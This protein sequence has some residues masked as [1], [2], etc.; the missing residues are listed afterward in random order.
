MQKDTGSGKHIESESVRLAG[1]YLAGER[2]A[3]DELIRLHQK[4]VFNLCFRILGD[5]DEADDCAQEV[6]IKVSRSL[7]GFRLEA[8]FSTWLHRITVNTC[9]NRLNSLDYRLKSRKIR[10]DMER[11]M[12]QKSQ[13]IEIEDKSQSPAREVIR[14]ELD[15]L[16]QRAINSLPARQKLVIV[17]RD[18]EG[19]SYEEI[20]EITGFKL[21]TVKSKLSRAREQ[22]RESLKGMI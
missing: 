7:K 6:F 1:E 19:R 3:F 13:P 12:D 18:I 21:G 22:L 2:R 10:I 5:Y 4:Q 11:D 15:R 17:L 20:G 9:K 8:A 14:K 16:I